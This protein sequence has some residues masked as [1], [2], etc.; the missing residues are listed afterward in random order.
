MAYRRRR[1]EE[2]NRWFVW[3]Y[4]RREGKQL[5]SRVSVSRSVERVV[6]CSVA[7]RKEDIVLISTIPHEVYLD[8]AAPEHQIPRRRSAVMQSKPNTVVQVVQ[9]RA[10]R[11]HGL[12]ANG[13]ATGGLGD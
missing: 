13:H 11:K 5:A 12:R 9:A 10:R 2:G 4:S 1:W 8:T 6:G 3:W 7:S